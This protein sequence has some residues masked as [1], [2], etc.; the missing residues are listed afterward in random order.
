MEVCEWTH[1]KMGSVWN[2]P[3]GRKQGIKCRPNEKTC[4]CVKDGKR[5]KI[6]RTELDEID[7]SEKAFM[8]M[9]KQFK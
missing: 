7:P 3:C 4:L 6:K 2:L 1:Y 8:D 9:L 5:H